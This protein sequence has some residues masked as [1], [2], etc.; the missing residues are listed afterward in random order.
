[1]R[2]ATGST[3]TI[4]ATGVA[5]EPLRAALQ[6]VVCEH[7]TVRGHHDL[8][9]WHHPAGGCRSAIE[10]AIFKSIGAKPG[11]PDIF[12]LH[13]GRRFGLE[14]K[15]ENGRLSPTRR[16]HMFCCAKPAQ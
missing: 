14:L 1:M 8:Y 11:L 15:S 6:R 7:L 2:S 3:S 10:A 13:R 5:Y 16:R 9:W 4:S 12:I